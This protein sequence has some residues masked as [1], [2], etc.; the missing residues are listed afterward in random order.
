MDL[1][2]LYLANLL[3]V[4]RSISFALS[5][6]DVLS[7]GK[8]YIKDKF[9]KPGNVYLGLV[10]RLDRPVS[11][12]MVLARTSKAANRLSSQFRENSVKKFYLAIVEGKCKGVGICKDYL[13]K[14]NQTTKIVGF[15][16]FIFYV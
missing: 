5:E 8:L 1:I 10:H 4:L 3:V 2:I 15:F 16:E 11:G 9:K 6:P 14:E 13:L 12:V 7:I